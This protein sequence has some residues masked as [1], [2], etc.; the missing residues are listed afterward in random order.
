MTTPSAET[1]C[2]L[3]LVE[4][5]YAGGF[6]RPRSVPAVNAPPEALEKL[7]QRIRGCRLCALHKFRSSVVPGEG[8]AAPRLLLVGEGPGA[9]E[10]RTGRP[11]VGKAGQYLD[12]WLEAIG[13]ERQ[14][15]CYITN[16]VKCR[17]PNNRDPQPEESDA[18][19]PYLK[20]QLA[21]MRPRV[22]CTLGRVSSQILTG[23]SEGIGA[24]RGRSYLYNGIPLVPTYHPS[25]V[26]RNTDLR[27]AVWED[28]KLVQSLLQN[29]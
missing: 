22:I 12:K 16:I 10:D 7:G 26:L 11:F 28:L 13:L 6:R 14:N 29:D 24:L 8:S 27:K 4:D 2:F 19:L 18:C 5:F 17:P 1:G 23:H 25:A 21:L 20:E 15:D 3:D 9:Q